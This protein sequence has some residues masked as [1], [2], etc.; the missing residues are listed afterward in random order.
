MYISIAGNYEYNKLS[1]KR[2]PTRANKDQTLK[3]RWEKK[4]LSIHHL[5]IIRCLAYIHVLKKIGLSFTLKN[6]K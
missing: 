4:K 2:G 5:K 1:Y 3:E 6:L